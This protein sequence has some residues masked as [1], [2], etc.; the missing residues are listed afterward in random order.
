MQS[1][2][3]FLAVLSEIPDPRRAEGKIYKLPYVLL[4]S[5]LAVVTGGNSFRSIETFIKVHRR[6][7]NSFGLRWQRAPA[8]TAIRYILQGLDT[9]AVEWVF[10]RRSRTRPSRS[11]PCTVKK[12][13]EAAAQAQARLIV[14]LKDNQPTLL[15]TFG[16][17]AENCL[18]WPIIEFCGCGIDFDN[19]VRLGID[20][21]DPRLHCSRLSLLTFARSRQAFFP[22][23]CVQL[24]SA[25]YRPRTGRSRASLRWLRPRQKFQRPF[26]G[27]PGG[28]QIRCI[29]WKAALSSGDR[30]FEHPLYPSRYCGGVG[31]SYI[32]LPIASAAEY[33]NA[34]SIALLQYWIT[35]SASVRM[36]A[37][38]AASA[39]A[40]KRSSLLRSE[41]RPASRV[42]W[43]IR[44]TSAV[45]RQQL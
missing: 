5:I 29:S 36:I 9:Q 6:R 31:Q 21:H 4:F 28:H 42:R 8:H 25:G 23:P 33:Q 32:R 16:S 18:L 1:F 44:P 45:V 35:P 37:S 11:T 10:R 26:S 40:R 14:Q 30:H 19:R 41:S 38:R 7:L 39:I 34:R 15:R 17:N 12:P 24:Y 43:H 27:G 2:D 13:F 22:P 20:Y 3:Q